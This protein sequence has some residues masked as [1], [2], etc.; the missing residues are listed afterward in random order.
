M[1]LIQFICIGHS[2]PPRSLGAVDG[3]SVSRRAEFSGILTGMVQYMCELIGGVSL[4]M[5]AT[6][7]DRRG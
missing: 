4:H 3:G 2:W 7:E 1:G 5:T 6:R